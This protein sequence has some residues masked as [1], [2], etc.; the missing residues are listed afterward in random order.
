MKTRTPWH[1]AAY[2]ARKTVRKIDRRL[3]YRTP[4]VA[5]VNKGTSN[6]LFTLELRYVYRPHK[7]PVSPFLTGIRAKAGGRREMDSRA[8]QPL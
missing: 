1:V 6:V 5:T 3:S 2:D 7:L 4:Y 8:P